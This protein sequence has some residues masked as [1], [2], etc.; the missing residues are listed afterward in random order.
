[1]HQHSH[2]TSNIKVAFF[3]NLGFTIIELVG[4]ILTNSV[5][6]MSDA[7]HDLGDSFSLGLAWYFEKISEKE[8]DDQFSFGYKRFSLLGALVNSIILLV[9]SVFILTKTIPRLLHP[10]PTNAHGMLWIAIL[11]IIINGVAVFR[12]KGG[13]NLNEKVISLHLLEDV[14]GWIAVFIGSIVMIYTE[15]TIID[16]I[17]SILISCFILYNVFKN[18]RLSFNIILQRTP[19]NIN[20]GLIKQ[21]VTQL[22]SIK[23]VYDIHSWSMDGIYNVLTMHITVDNTASLADINSLKKVIRAILKEANV[24]HSTLEIDYEKIKLDPH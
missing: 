5:A 21:K 13:K 12:L 19:D 20:L 22:S 6:I 18:L 3:L 4:G 10:E 23:E 8:R 2:H 14:F 7:L 17:L 11:G 9:G 1:M 15:I 16:P 24:S